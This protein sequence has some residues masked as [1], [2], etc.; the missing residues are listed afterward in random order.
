[1]FEISWKPEV[2]PHRFA[3]L[4]ETFYFWNMWKLQSFSFCCCAVLALT[5]CCPTGVSLVPGSSLFAP[6]C[7]QTTHARL[8]HGVTQCSNCIYGLF[9]LANGP[10]SSLF[11]LSVSHNTYTD[12]FF[13][14][15]EKRN[16]FE[17]ACQCFTAVCS[18]SLKCWYIIWQVTSTVLKFCS[19]PERFGSWLCD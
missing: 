17:D 13:L 7:M 18:Y 3:V 15:G 12:A 1:M 14:E 2:M 5:A 19:T 10:I 16:V 11:L 8:R 4:W 6:F 9:S